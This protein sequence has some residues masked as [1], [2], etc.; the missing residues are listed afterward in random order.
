MRSVSRP[1]ER[2][3]RGFADDPPS[4]RVVSI[5]RNE[6]N[7]G[8][9]PPLQTT[10]PVQHHVERGPRRTLAQDLLNAP[11]EQPL[12]DPFRVET[13]QVGDLA[14][15]PDRV[16][17]QRR[18]AVQQV[19]QHVVVRVADVGLGVDEQ[20]RPAWSPRLRARVI[21]RICRRAGLPPL[22]QAERSVC[23]LGP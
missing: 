5:S 17:L 15:Q 6:L 18:V 4:C 14:Q 1:G 21:R 12:A 8:G 2:D 10:Q 16:R 13:G 3:D 19:P 11:R 9:G 23:L 7:E 22:D 20:P